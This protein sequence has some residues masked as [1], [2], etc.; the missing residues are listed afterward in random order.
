MLVRCLLFRNCFRNQGKRSNIDF[1]YIKIK[2]SLLESLHSQ[3]IFGLE[4][5]HPILNMIKLSGCWV[6]ILSLFF[7]TPPCIPIVTC[8]W[9]CIWCFMFKSTIK[10]TAIADV[11]FSIEW[12]LKAFFMA[13][14]HWKQKY[15][16]GIVWL[17]FYFCLNS[18][19]PQCWAVFLS[20]IQQVPVSIELTS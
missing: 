3:H 7:W 13:S 9:T 11:V 4:S 1:F 5:Q 12:T 6:W 19:W 16:L 18:W 14:S 20:V 17:V 8:E 2:H 10:P 15:I